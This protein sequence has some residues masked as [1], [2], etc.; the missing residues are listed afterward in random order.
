MADLPIDGH[1]IILRGGSMVLKFGDNVFIKPM[2]GVAAQV[3]LGKIK[4][5]PE[6]NYM[7]GTSLNESDDA[8][9]SDSFS[10]G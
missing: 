1:K 4:L 5:L 7:H 6:L 10:A 2:L 8:G 3:R 9:N